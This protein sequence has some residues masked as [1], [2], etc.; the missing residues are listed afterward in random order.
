VTHDTLYLS[1]NPGGKANLAPSHPLQSTIQS[2]R[3]RR[4]PN[5]EPG[6]HVWG[7]KFRMEAIYGSTFNIR[8][9]LYSQILSIFFTPTPPV[10]TGSG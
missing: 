6:T 9:E 8:K 2:G 5:P 7:K 4:S 10:L 3:T 1:I